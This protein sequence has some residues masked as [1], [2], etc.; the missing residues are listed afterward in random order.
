MD[1]A[2]YVTK[3]YV[4]ILCVA[5]ALANICARNTSKHTFVLC[6]CVAHSLESLVGRSVGRDV[7]T[8]KLLFSH[9]SARYVLYFEYSAERSTKTRTHTRTPKSS[10]RIMKQ[11][12]QH[13]QWYHCAHKKINDKILLVLHLEFIQMDLSIFAEHGGETT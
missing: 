7:C 6:Q 1:L 13:E 8:Q 10:E 12:Q 4:H 5:L 9:S 3:A 2:T 11:K